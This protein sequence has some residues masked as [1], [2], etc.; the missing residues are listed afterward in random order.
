MMWHGQWGVMKN[1]IFSLVLAFLLVLFTV[2]ACKISEKPRISSQTKPEIS[3][4]SQTISNISPTTSIV[5]SAIATIVA[6]ATTQTQGSNTQTALNAIDILSQYC[7]SCHDGSSCCGGAVLK[8]GFPPSDVDVALRSGNG[9]GMPS[10]QTV[11]S[12]DQ[13]NAVVDYLS[14]GCATSTPTQTIL[15][16]KQNGNLTIQLFSDHNPPVQGYDVFQIL[17]TDSNG[18]PVSDATVSLDLNMTTMNMGNNHVAAT[19]L[20]KGYYAGKVFFSMPGPWQ[21]TVGIQRNGQTT[22]VQFKFMVN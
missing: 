11:L 14:G 12:E 15:D 19:P 13:I 6:P 3:A 22:T 7:V 18:Q 16:Q 5:T 20:G 2:S 17:V 1:K 4:P 8:V 21:A 9:A 10:F